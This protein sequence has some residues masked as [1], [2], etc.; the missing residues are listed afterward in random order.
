MKS[1]RCGQQRVNAEIFATGPVDLK[2]GDVLERI[3]DG[4]GTL[5]NQL[6]AGRSNNY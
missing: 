6:F 2:Q 1:I 3:V 5:R 4:L